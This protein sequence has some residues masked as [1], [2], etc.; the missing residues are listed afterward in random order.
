MTAS[1]GSNRKSGTD[2]SV[3][4][5][6]AAP[7]A[8]VVVGM[9]ESHVRSR[10][11]RQL[12]LSQS[13]CS[14][15]SSVNTEMGDHHFRGLNHLTCKSLPPYRPIEPG[16]GLGGGRI[17]SHGHAVHY[18]EEIR[19]LHGDKYLSLSPTVPHLSSPSHP[20]Y[21]FQHCPHPRPIPVAFIPIPATVSSIP[22]R[23]RG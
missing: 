12:R 2:I 6:A 3:R 7:L 10:W 19:E 18:R 8:L 20:N 13:S 11:R 16:H 22:N 21:Y 23:P 14:T 9:Y 1:A 17:R 5:D 4:Y 15:F